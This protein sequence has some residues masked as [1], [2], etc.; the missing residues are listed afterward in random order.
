[1]NLKPNVPDTIFH[2]PTLSSEE[3]LLLAEVADEAYNDTASIAGW[4]VITPNLTDFGLTENLI[5]GNSYR[6]EAPDIDSGDANATIFKSQISDTLVLA[7]RGTETAQGDRAYWIGRRGFYDLFNPLFNAFN[8][9]IQE[10][11]PSKIL[12]TGHSLGGAMVEYFMVDNPG[13]QYA[14]VAFASPDATEDSLETRILNIG[15][16][17][18][19]VYSI[20]GISSAQNSTT[21]L[22]TV[23]GS[24][25]GGGFFSFEEHA[26]QQ[27]IYTTNRILTSEYYDQMEKD[28]LVIIDRTDDWNDIYDEIPV[29]SNPDAFIL[30]E[31]DDDD[32]IRGG[33]G[34]D[35]LEGLGGNDTLIGDNFSS[36]S[37][38]DTLDGGAGNDSLDGGEGEDTAIYS[39]AVVNYDFEISD[40]GEIVTITHARGTQSDGTDTLTNV[41][42]GE[43][44][45]RRVQLLGNTLNFVN[46][47]VVG[48]TQDTQ[49]IF[50][51]IREGETSFPVTVFVDGQVTTGNAVFNDFPSTLE[52]GSN[53]NLIIGASVSEVFGDVAFS[54]EI[55]VE[56]DNPLSGLI[57]IED[58]DAS[59]VLIGDQVDNR[60]GRT[61]GDPHLITFDNLAYDFQAS[62]DFILAKATAGAE[63]EVQARFV[64]LSSA[65]SVTEAMATSVDGTVISLEA[66]GSEGKLL[67]DGAATTI[68]DGNSVTVGSGSISRIG[69]RYDIDYGNGDSTSVDVFSSFINVSPSPSITRNSGEIEGLLGNANGNPSDD[70]QLDDGTILSTPLSAEILYGDYAASWLVDEN[71]SMLPGV[72]EEYV[73]PTRIITIDSLPEILRLSAEAAV[74]AFGITNPVLREAAILDFA[75]TNNQEFIEAAKLTDNTFDPIVGTVAVDPVIDPVVI[76]TSNLAELDEED[77]SARRATLTV[78]RGSSEGDLTV[79]YSIE[80]VGTEPAEANDFLDGIVTGEVV[81]EDGADFGTFDIE[82]VDDSLVEGTETFDVSI[83]LE[84]E[85]AS[86][87]ELLVSSLRFSIIND[88]EDTS[89]VSIIPGTPGRDSLIGD[90]ANNVITGFQSRDILTGNGGADQFVYTDIRDAGDIITDFELGSDKIV[91][92]QLLD[93]LGYAG[94]DA[95][96]DGYVS[97]G[98]SRGDALVQIDRDGMGNGFIPRALV[99][100]Q[101]VTEENLS[102]NAENSF[103]F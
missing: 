97:F 77:A 8:S 1:M 11:K 62:G 55:S 43:F 25:H 53:P 49:V 98:S 42:F 24:E 87:F 5:R 61:F 41:E 18:D 12:V 3:I 37:G 66:D 73:A 48:T 2:H 7:F 82:I 46:D 23:I 9:Y 16:E 76:L 34:N 22:Y 85:Q 94:S 44:S 91:L 52:A 59:G 64:A 101:G 63:Y 70:F 95:I 33:R 84:D 39:E 14:A 60:G 10:N 17:N 27:Y 83:A 68:A 92:T 21:N 6:R 78:A 81:I 67:I 72:S 96:G 93:S 47:F 79:N 54:L 20:V 32:E 40:D 51:L 28:S 35:I 30:G 26:Q 86:S 56:D 65:V 50:D 75:L 29:F 99:L 36:F 4:D 58:N 80:G 90:S 88:D 13:N 102:A 57:L 74:D 71:T 89:S 69:Q 15:H 100:L 31:D 38:N 45:D 103:I 19:P